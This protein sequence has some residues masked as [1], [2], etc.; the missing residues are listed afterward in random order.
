MSMSFLVVVLF[1]LTAFAVLVWAITSKAKIEKRMADPKAPKST[2]AADTP[3]K[4]K[5]ADV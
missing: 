3:A 4:G 5:P 2:L 1:L